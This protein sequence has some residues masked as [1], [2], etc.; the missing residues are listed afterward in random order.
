MIRGLGNLVSGE[1]SLPDL[2]T[3]TFSVSYHM[4]FPL[5]KAGGGMGGVLVSLPL[6][7]LD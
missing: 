6:L 1:A 4:V 7:L 2:K 3:A 5:C